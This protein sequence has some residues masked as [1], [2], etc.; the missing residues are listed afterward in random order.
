MRRRSL[1]ICA[2]I[3][4]LAV[5]LIFP[6]YKQGQFPQCFSLAPINGVVGG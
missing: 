2:V 6:L 3:C 5:L 4:L 1:S